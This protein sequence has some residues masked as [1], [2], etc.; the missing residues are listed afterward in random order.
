MDLELG[1]AFGYHPLPDSIPAYC[2]LEI[3]TQKIIACSMTL[4]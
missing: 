4:S 3:T 2:P 1:L